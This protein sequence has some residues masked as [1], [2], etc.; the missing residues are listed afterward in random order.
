M[1]VAEDKWWLVASSQQCTC[2][3][4]SYR[5]GFY[6]LG[7]TSHHPGLS[8]PLHHRFS[9]LQLLAFPKAEIAIEREEISDHALD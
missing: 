8:A 9:F 6:F 2:P 5:A 3:F 4:Y 1:A 7:K